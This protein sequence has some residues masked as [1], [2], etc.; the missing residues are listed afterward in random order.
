MDKTNLTY[1]EIIYLF[2]D[3][4]VPERS[5][6]LTYDLHPT[7]EK[8]SAKPLSYKMILAALVYLQDKG[9]ISFSVK[10]VKKLIFLSGKDIFAKRTKEA[11]NL[12]GIEQILMD[13]IKKEANVRTAVYY[14]LND[15]ESSPWG[16]VINI[17]KNSLVEKGFL[18][19]EKKQAIFSA[20][21]YFFNQEK[22][23]EVQPL[24]E[25]VKKSIVSISSDNELYKLLESAVKKGIDARKEQSTSDD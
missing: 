10:E 14:I 1:S 5:K 18:T 16:Q 17:A 7:G 21:K 3:Q 11:K 24:L 19:I 20:K 6:F 25:N 9:L 23:K 4:I 13:Y 2:A 8:I 15:D 12:T 22:V